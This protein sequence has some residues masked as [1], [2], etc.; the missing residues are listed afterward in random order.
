MHK[1]PYLR[2]FLIL[3]Q[4]QGRR[5]EESP[6]IPPMQVPIENLDFTLSA[7]YNIM[8]DYIL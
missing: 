5:A 3:S 6:A 2:I 8:N 7:I 4:S 1:T